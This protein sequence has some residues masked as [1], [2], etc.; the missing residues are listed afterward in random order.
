ME[1]MAADSKV[2][3]SFSVRDFILFINDS[4]AAAS[5]IFEKIVFSH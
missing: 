5:W 2:K 4:F 1:E 3:A